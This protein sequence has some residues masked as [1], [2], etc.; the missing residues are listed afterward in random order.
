MGYLIV[1]YSA[2]TV[3]SF[4]NFGNTSYYIVH[5]LL[6]GALGLFIVLGGCLQRHDEHGQSAQAE[7]E[8][9]GTCHTGRA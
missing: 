9:F 7:P 2:S 1:L 8:S 5:Q 6:Y 4:A 3:Q